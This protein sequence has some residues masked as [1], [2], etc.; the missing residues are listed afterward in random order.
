MDLDALLL[1]IESISSD[2]SSDESCESAEDFD[3][4]ISDSEWMDDDEIDTSTVVVRGCVDAAS[5]AQFRK[6]GIIKYTDAFEHVRLVN[7]E[8]HVLTSVRVDVPAHHLCPDVYVLDPCAYLSSFYGAGYKVT[9]T[10]VRCV[11][12]CGLEE[13]DDHV[14]PSTVTVTSD[15]PLEIRRTKGRGRHRRVDVQE[16]L[17]RFRAQQAMTFKEACAWWRTCGLK[18]RVIGDTSS[19]CIQLHCRCGGYHVECPSPPMKECVRCHKSVRQ[20]TTAK[21]GTPS[22]PQTP[23]LCQ[24]CRVDEHITC[25]ECKQRVRRQ[26]YCK[27]LPGETFRMSRVTTYPPMQR[28]FNSKKGICVDCREVH[29]VQSYGRHQLRAHCDLRPDMFGDRMYKRMKCYLCTFKTCDSH[30][31]RLHER[32]HYTRKDY[33]CTECTKTYSSLSAMHSHRRYKHFVP[34]THRGVHLELKNGSFVEVCQ[35][36]MVDI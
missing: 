10:R 29:S 13:C 16:L 31:L 7:R 19:L 33:K 32:S 9:G 23:G 12:P 22:L 36:E 14:I 8:L 27:V 24:Q 28:A 2:E 4:E 3:S 18:V 35:D 15:F 17:P 34:S 25:P 1:N 5:L 30:A 26:H 20:L 21:M 11:C 6:R